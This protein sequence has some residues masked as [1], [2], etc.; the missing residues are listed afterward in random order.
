MNFWKL[1]WFYFFFLDAFK[2]NNLNL[3]S[4]LNIN[5]IT[6]PYFYSISMDIGSPNST[7]FMF[8]HKWLLQSGV[9]AIIHSATL[10]SEN[11]SSTRWPDVR[12]HG[13][14]RPRGHQRW[15]R[16]R[17]LGTQRHYTSLWCT[18]QVTQPSHLNFWIN[19]M[20]KTPLMT[21]GCCHYLNL[22]RS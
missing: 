9:I 19:N 17:G 22:V 6:S 15:V 1:R 18:R 10:H 5:T 2:L 14:A 4:L 20:E 21:Q 12:H 13:G 8:L 7:K 11:F 3:D 16:R